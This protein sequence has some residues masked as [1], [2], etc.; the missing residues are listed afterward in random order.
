MAC[1]RKAK[2]ATAREGR[3]GPPQS[4]WDGTRIAGARGGAEVGALDF[5]YLLRERHNKNRL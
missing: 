3:K 5:N 2:P 1:P 4:I